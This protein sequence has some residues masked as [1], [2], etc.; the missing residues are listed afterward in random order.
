MK[1]K[2][3]L[4]TA[5]IALS[6][7]LAAADQAAYG[8]EFSGTPSYITPVTIDYFNDEGGQYILDSVTIIMS[9]RTIGEE[10]LALDNESSSDAY[11]TVSLGAM[12]DVRRDGS[13]LLSLTA[14][15]SA[16][17]ALG[18]DDGDDVNS[19]QTSGDDY[20]TVT[21]SSA[22]RTGITE[23]DSSEF[24][25]YIWDG[26]SSTTFELTVGM[27][28]YLSFNELSGASYTGNT[29]ET[30]GLVTVL[31]DYHVVPEPATIGMLGMGAVIMMFVRKRSRR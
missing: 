7:S 28:Q 8:L 12:G 14:I 9:I 2:T 29:L 13:V 27:N 17:V 30:E 20:G 1:T 11:A 3:V 22:T 21:I 31:Y 25:D 24:G 6:A 18:A 10:I 26:N 16:S 4:I 19:V 15:S 23:I 5:L